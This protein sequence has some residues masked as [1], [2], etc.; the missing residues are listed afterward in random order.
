M[1]SFIAA[2]GS[3]RST[4]FIPA[5]PAAWS[6]TTIAFMI[7]GLLS[8]PRAARR[9]GAIASILAEGA[10]CARPAQQTQRSDAAGL[11][12]AS[13]YLHKKEVVARDGLP[14]QAR[15]YG[16]CVSPRHMRRY[17]EPFSVLLRPAIS[18]SPVRLLPVRR[19]VAG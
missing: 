4:S 19:G 17:R 16:C 18:V 2:G 9:L 5:V 10:A 12:R 6:V 14:G 15:Q 8:C 1:T 11:T 3:G 13:I 7:G